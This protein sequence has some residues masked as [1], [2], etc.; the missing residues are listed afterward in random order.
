MVPTYGAGR[1]GGAGESMPLLK[2]NAATHEKE[3]L[4]M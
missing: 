3:K 2:A 4:E 1:A